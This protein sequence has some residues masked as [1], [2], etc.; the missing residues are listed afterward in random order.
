MSDHL[1]EDESGTRD[2]SLEQEA[3]AEVNL[4]EPD[5][6]ADVAWSPPERRPVSS[7]FA[8]DDA[9]EE[10]I[11]QRISQEVP[12]E[13]TSYGRP[14]VGGEDTAGDREP[15]LLGGDDP[16]AIPADQD[17]LGGD[18]DLELEQP[19]ARSGDPAEEAAMHLSE[20]DEGEDRP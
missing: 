10:T 12:E 17:V 13:G 19:A 15:E 5:A 9:A 2:Y 20:G 1:Y 8:D 18:A 14:E 16:D 7:E 11:D 3:E 6:T 4:D